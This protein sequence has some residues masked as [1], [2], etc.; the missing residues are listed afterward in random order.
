MILGGVALAVILVLAVIADR[1]GKRHGHIN[2][3][4]DYYEGNPMIHVAREV[5]TPTSTG[6][7][8]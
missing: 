8:V 4:Q 5:G 1:R 7:G 2:P 6:G 3:P